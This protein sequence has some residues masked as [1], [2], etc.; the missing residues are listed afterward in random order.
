MRKTVLTFALMLALTGIARAG[1]MLTP[2]APPPPT[3][4]P[5]SEG[6]MLQPLTET[7]ET[8]IE[9]AFNLG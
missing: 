6:V 2:V 3:P 5:S 7:I 4:P 9:I 1:E 8:I